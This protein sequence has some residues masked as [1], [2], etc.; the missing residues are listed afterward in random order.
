MPER[1]RKLHLGLWMLT[2][3]HHIASWR[4][5]KSDPSAILGLDFYIEAARLAEAGKF[6]M[7]FFEDTLAARERNGH[8]FGEVSIFSM[9]PLVSVAALA[10]ATEKIGLASSYSTTYHLP[11]VLAEK[12]AAIDRL[13]GGRAA[14]N[15]VTSGP[16]GARNY[17]LGEHPDRP[18]RYAMAHDVVAI[19]KA[20]WDSWADDAFVFD[21]AAG[22]YYDPAKVRPVDFKGQ[23]EAV[24]GPLTTPRPPQGYPVFIQAGQSEWGMDF[25]ASFAEVIF[26]AQ[27]TLEGGQAFRSQMRAKVAGFGRSPDAMKVMPG[28][29]PVVGA[30]EAEAR[31]KEEYFRKLV[32]PRIQMGLLSERFNLDLSPYPMDGPFPMA[33]IMAHLEDRANIG[34]ERSRFLADIREDDTIGSYCQRMIARTYA[35]HQYMAGDPEQIADHMGTWLREGGC[36]GFILMPPLVPGELKVFVEQVVPVLQAKGYFREDYEGST[37]RDHFGLARPP[38]GD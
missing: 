2:T 3:G 24:R 13:S 25:A 35:G 31:E 28:Y 7:V 16:A 34:G 19:V 30:T 26:C 32:H 12:F 33:D 8:I 20:L 1:E 5:P 21:Q 38:R 36:D 23:W 4:H 29:F 14:W 11:Y 6:D 37:L 15:L 9:D 18:T 10:L 17:G 27:R 22:L